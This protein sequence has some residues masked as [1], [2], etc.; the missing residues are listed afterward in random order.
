MTNQ[1]E[2]EWLKD[3]EKFLHSD[4]IEVPPDLKKSVTL[5]IQKQMN[6]RAFQVFLKLIIFHLVTG[7]LSLAI[8]HQFGINPFNTQFSFDTLMMRYVGHRACMLG[9]GVLFVSSSFLA[10]G[11]FLSVEELK[12]L[13]RT[14]ALQ[15][16]SI[17]L[18][19]LG[20]FISAGAEIALSI[21]LLWV[22]GA[23]L[24]GVL[25]SHIVWKL[26]QS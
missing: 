6:P 14:G 2:N 17:A 7:Y 16:A 25:T 21:A 10:A 19:S 8:C 26:K 4:P 9:C 11:Y 24:G 20:L 12:V 22:T 23:I 13:K 5:Q 18:I 3:Y 1:N 15:T